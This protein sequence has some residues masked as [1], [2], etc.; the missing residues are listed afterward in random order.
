MG[1]SFPHPVG[2]FCTHLEPPI[3][4]LIQKIYF[5]VCVFYHTPL[6]L[7]Q[8]I[9]NHFYRH[10]REFPHKNLKRKFIIIEYIFEFT[11]LMIFKISQFK[12]LH[13]KQYFGVQLF[14]FDLVCI[15]SVAESHLEHPQ[16]KSHNVLMCIAFDEFSKNLE[17]SSTRL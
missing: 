14:L 15:S 17:I 10:S 2:V 13:D 8:I 6:K 7:F 4:H 5:Q 16:V 12:L 9:Q 11:F 3:C 1:K